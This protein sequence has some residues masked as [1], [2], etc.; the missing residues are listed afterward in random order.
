MTDWR[1]PGERRDLEDTLV[2]DMSVDQLRTF[3]R[4]LL[5]VNGDL[6]SER[7]GH[8]KSVEQAFRRR[9]NQQRDE[10]YRLG[11]DLPQHQVDRI[12]ALVKSMRDAES[13]RRKTA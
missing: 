13:T 8:L 11:A 10:L 5:R 2:D 9:H 12:A 4:H 6:L 7:E 3:A 1:F